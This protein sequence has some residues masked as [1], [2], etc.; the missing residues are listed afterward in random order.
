MQVRGHLQ[1]C[2]GRPVPLEEIGGLTIG[3]MKAMEAA[4]GPVAP[5]KPAPAAKKA[6]VPTPSMPK[7]DKPADVAP[8]T[9]G[10]VTPTKRA[11]SLESLA[12]SSPN[13]PST[14]APNPK[15]VFGCQV[16]LVLV[17]PPWSSN[18][19]LATLPS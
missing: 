6:A 8:T 1:R 18:R 7:A 5:S 4:L 13:L 11:A 17:V 12:P 10:A 3:K 9:P 19:C 14:P 15:V 16:L 2:L